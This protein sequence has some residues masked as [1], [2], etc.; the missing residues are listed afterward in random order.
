[1]CNG[2]GNIFRFLNGTSS[3]P[4]LEK[5]FEVA[6]PDRTQAIA[7]AFEFEYFEA[8]DETSLRKE[9]PCF[10]DC[11]RQAILAVRTPAQTNAEILR[12]YFRM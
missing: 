8:C 2:G 9:L 7:A 3:L 5:Y 10:Y 1:M 6:R 11:P 4:E 12:R